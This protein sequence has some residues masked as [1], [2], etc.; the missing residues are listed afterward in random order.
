MGEAQGVL[1]ASAAER[2][3]HLVLRS[4][5]RLTSCGLPTDPA[6][7]NLDIWLATEEDTLPGPVTCKTCL[8]RATKLV[9]SSRPPRMSFITVFQHPH[10][11]PKQIV[12]RRF[13]V[14]GSKVVPSDLIA[15]GST[16]RDVQATLTDLGFTR[17]ARSHDDVPEV[18]EVWT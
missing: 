17:H 6:N 18:L 2:L 8:R 9:L 3:V 16:L 10:D 12:A 15:T 13:E 7:G 4:A 11:Y 14:E 5:P 1:T